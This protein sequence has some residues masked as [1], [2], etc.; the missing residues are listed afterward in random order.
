LTSKKFDDKMPAAAAVAKGKQPP[1]ATFDVVCSLFLRYHGR[2][3]THSFEVLY[4]FEYLPNTV[5]LGILLSIGI[6]A[7]LGMVVMENPQVQE[8]LDQQR[9]KIIELLR[10]VG[11]DLDPESRRAAEAFAFE[12]R[13]PE[14][15]EGIRREANASIEAAAI[16]TGRSLSNPNTVRRIPVSG[17]TDPDALA[18]RRRMGQAYLAQREQQ[19]FEMQQRRSIASLEGSRVASRSASFDALVHQD[20]SLKT[21]TEPV[22]TEQLPEQVRDA[23]R[24]VERQLEMPIAAGS[25]A[26][27]ASSGW[28]MGSAFANPFSDEYE[29]DRSM[30]PRPPAVPPKVAMSEAPDPEIS[31]PREMTP[32]PIAPTL[33]EE[34]EQD[35]DLT[36][37][38][39]LAIALS[40]SEQES[41]LASAAGHDAQGAAEDAA[42]HAAV[43]A[44]LKEM[45]RQQGGY[46]EQ[47][48]IDL[49]S[50]AQPVAPVPTR[51]FWNSAFRPDS[52]SQ[53]L[54]AMGERIHNPGSAFPAFGLQQNNND[55]PKSR[56]LSPSAETQASFTSED[57]YRV[58]P[59][60]TQA[61]LASLTAANPP[62]DAVGRTLA[63]A[64]PPASDTASEM[65]HSAPSLSQQLGE[66]YGHHG[67]LSRPTNDQP[68]ASNAQIFASVS[69][70]TDLDAEDNAAL[71]VD[72]TRTPQSTTHHSLGFHPVDISDTQS[73]AASV[74]L[75][76]E[77]PVAPSVTSA[78]EVVEVE[79]ITDIDMLSEEGD[80]VATPTD[81]WSQ[82]DER[83]ALEEE[84]DEDEEFL[85]RRNQLVGA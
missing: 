50:S 43:A 24:E 4:L 36:Y 77:T 75:S 66:I 9:R 8:W 20:G 1:L 83:E 15:D 10:T 39:Q 35:N 59:Q 71:A 31:V 38:E 67:P 79:D 70:L 28:Q 54:P 26:A 47:P 45:A 16:A 11:A 13:T 65:F 27:V 58:T 14:N 73:L 82:V 46:S 6:I 3:P 74:T 7:A 17:P 80:G 53:G 72:G 63:A 51:P 81:S 5:V 64:S 42:F 44:S 68:P 21:G 2:T 30:T 34:A 61:H 85:Q 18:E 57:L 62:Y 32:R 40:I 76:R 60:L 29:M 33:A 55:Q 41:N 12:G 69:A 22:T 84:D 56:T 19:M 49:A 52:S 48:L 25:S 37:E 78:P 23:A